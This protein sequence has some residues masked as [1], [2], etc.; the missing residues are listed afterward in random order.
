MGFNSGF[1]GLMLLISLISHVHNNIGLTLKMPDLINIVA[2][3]QYDFQ[4]SINKENVQARWV[5]THHASA[6]LTF[7]LLSGCTVTRHEVS[8]GQV[9]SEERLQD[10]HIYSCYSTED[11][12]VHT[13]SALKDP[14]FNSFSGK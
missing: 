13:A 4:S 9:V 10:F 7:L 6:V 11:D 1:K 2:P 12:N 5:L 3:D 8:K 14:M